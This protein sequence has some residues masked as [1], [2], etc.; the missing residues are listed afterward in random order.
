MVGRL[1]TGTKPTQYQTFANIIIPKRS[2]I[3]IALLI[4]RVIDTKNTVINLENASIKAPGILG[5]MLIDGKI[6]LILDLYNILEN[7]EPE[8]VEKIEINVKK[9]QSKH[10]FLVEDTPFFMKV[11]KECM[12][13]AGYQVSTAMN[14]QEGLEML[15]KK[16]FDLVLSDIEMPF[17]DGREM[18][19][20]IRANPRWDAMSIIAIT[21][22]ND[23]QTIV[24]GKKAGFNE[25]LVKLDRE[26]LLNLYL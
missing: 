4:N 20:N 3:P 16:A 12:V 13:G 21:T 7:G 6:T 9:A 22:L 14:G 25:W 17:M 5:S 15:Q 19:K 1:F 26:L 11:I 24:E 2:K 18:V 10:I 23:E 8:S